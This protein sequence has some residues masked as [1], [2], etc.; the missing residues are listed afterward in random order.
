M[1]V[2]SAGNAS[3]ATGRGEG[4][5]KASSTDVGGGFDIERFRYNRGSEVVYDGRE[6]LRGFRAALTVFCNSA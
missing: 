2:D 3:E 5:E 6:D 1:E 4:E